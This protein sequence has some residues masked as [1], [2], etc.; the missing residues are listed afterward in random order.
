MK[1]KL[2]ILKKD[3]VEVGIFILKKIQMELGCGDYENDFKLFLI[4]LNFI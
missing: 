1:D 2:K 3:L 4:I